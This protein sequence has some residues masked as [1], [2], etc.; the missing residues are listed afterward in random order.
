MRKKL[1]E[2]TVLIITSDH[3]EEFGEHGFK[4]HAKHLYE[5]VLRVP[6]IVSCPAMTAL[7][8]SV[9]AQVSSIDIVPTILE[10]VGIPG[11]DKI[12]G[13]TLAPMLEGTASPGRVAISQIGGNDSRMDSEFISINTGKHKLIWN[14]NKDIKELYHLSS[15]PQELRNLVEEDRETTAK[16]QSQLENMLF[17]PEEKAFRFK[18][19]PKTVTFD[20]H[21]LQRLRD[22]GYV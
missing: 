9:P 17:A 10:I 3:G 18:P 1:T 11:G 7:G 14:R 12:Q 16:L 6:L 4:Y 22:L 2:K 20:D 8:G 15:D 21:V 19:K 13:E 5:E